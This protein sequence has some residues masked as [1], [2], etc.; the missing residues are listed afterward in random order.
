MEW[1]GRLPRSSPA[2]ERV[3]E[4]E[5][6]PC[7]RASLVQSVRVIAVARKMKVSERNVRGNFI[8]WRARG[9]QN[10]AHVLPPERRNKVSVKNSH[11]QSTALGAR[12]ILSVRR[13]S[14]VFVRC[15]R[16]LLDRLFP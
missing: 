2:S 16:Q 4:N 9:L 15:T 12:E 1:T 5:P 8:A 14:S 7:L 13:K 6:P 11:A 10:P 3:V